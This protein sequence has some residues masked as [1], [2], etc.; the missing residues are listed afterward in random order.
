VP[1]VLVAA[2][3]AGFEPDLL[4]GL[5]ADEG[6]GPFRRYRGRVEL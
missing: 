3:L 1:G 2:E 4:S 6:R 5:L